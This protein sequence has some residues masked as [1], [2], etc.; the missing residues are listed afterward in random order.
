MTC[1]HR[2]PLNRECS[3]CCYHLDA[4]D[5]GRASRERSRRICATCILAAV[6]VVALAVILERVR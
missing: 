5:W 2:I 1:D 3:E 6:A 4:I